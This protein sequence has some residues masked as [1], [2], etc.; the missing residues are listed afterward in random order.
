MNMSLSQLQ[1]CLPYAVAMPCASTLHGT[2]HITIQAVRTDSRSVVPGDLFIALKGESFDGTE[3]LVQAQAQGAVAVLFEAQDMAHGSHQVY[4]K[5]VTVPAFCVPNARQALGDLSAA[6]RRQFDVALVGVTGSNGKTTVTQMIA[7]V[8]RAET[9]K[10]SMSTQGNL[11]NEIGVP[12]T[13]FNLKSEHCRA[14]VEL[15]MNHPGEIEVLARYAQPTI[16]LVNN[17]QREHQEYMATVEAVARENGEVIRAL[18]PE[19]VAVFPAADAYTSLW[20]SLAGQRRTLTFGFEVGDVQAHDM[21]WENGAW[22]FKLHAQAESL[23]CRLNI[24]GRHN[25]LNALAAAACALAAG[26]DLKTIVKG[27]ESFEP[28]KGRSKSS[29]MVIDGHAFTLV[30]DTYNAN[31]DS[32]RA[33]I[34]VLAELPA[35]RL[36]VLGDMG[37]VGQ[38]GPEFHQEVGAYAQAQG[39]QSLY[40]LGNLCVHSSQAFQG[41]QHFEDMNTLQQAVLKDMPHFQSVVVKGSRFMKMERV[42][43]A[44]RARAE[45]PLA[46]ERESVH[47]A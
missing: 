9:S 14:V 24:A 8:L 1:S 23:A 7:T 45:S 34:D 30:D 17:A 5:D 37:E 31:P 3:F 4:L 25:V 43:D 19:G 35:P 6:W 46:A 12:L 47:V 32:V 38:Q 2:S 26:M 16:G 18:P 39:I 27:L 41:A 11:N 33:A 10:P 15:G 21:A 13:L 42:V 28:V 20:Q 36:M 22:S 29:E 44:L 40:T